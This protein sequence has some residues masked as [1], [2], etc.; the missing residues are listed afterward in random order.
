MVRGPDDDADRRQPDFLQ[1][2]RHELGDW[3]RWM[4]RIAVMGAAAAAGLAVVAFVWLSELALHVFERLREAQPLAPLLWTPLCTAAAVWA[5]T[6]WAPGASGSGIPHVMAA[7]SSAVSERERPLFVSL[8]LSVAKLVL[9]TLGLLGGLPIGREGPAVQI[10][11]GVMH[12]ARRWLPARTSIS[13]HG[14]LVAGGAAG[15]AAAFNA[16]LAGVVFAIEQLTSK[17]EER[18]SGLVVAAI[19]FAGLIAVSVF[20][21]ATYFGVIRVPHLDLAIVGPG[22]L[23]VLGSGAGGGFFSRLLLA[24]LLGREDPVSRWRRRHPVAF[25]AACGLAVA[26]IG[27]LGGGIAFSSGYAYTRG[28]I[29]GAAGVTG[30]DVAM[31][32]VATWL[33]AWSGVSGGVFAP[34]LAIGA[35]IGSDVAQLAGVPQAAPVLIALGM[36]A[37]LAAVT[38]APITAFIIVMEM[39]DGHAM[40]LSLMAAAFTGATV[41]G[42]CSRP[43]Y[44]ALAEAQLLRLPPRPPGE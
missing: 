4:A 40:V 33:A 24:A 35:G 36:A 2:L 16:P 34:A 26:A 32:L 43:L 18:S 15:V 8:R 12:H 5:A 17:V 1:A 38:R 22:L 3:R 14:L 7:L 13:P 21:N 9:T 11:A 42:W 23:V 6:R 39:V 27:T 25:A 20:G 31:R 19:V 41:S 44:A 30:L 37:F 29:E 28:L 10:A